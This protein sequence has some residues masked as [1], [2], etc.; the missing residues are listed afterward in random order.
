MKLTEL[1][2]SYDTDMQDEVWHMFRKKLNK[3]QQAEVLKLFQIN[4]LTDVLD[5]DNKQ[6]EE[7]MRHLIE[8]TK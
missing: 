1:H 6:L 3:T 8:I 4:A 5:F 2:E 7:L